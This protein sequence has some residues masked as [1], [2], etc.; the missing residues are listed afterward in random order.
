M[1]EIWKDIAGYEKMYQVSN[2]GRVRSLDRY[3][4][5]GY[6]YWLQRGKILKPCQQK[7]GYLNVDLSDGHSKSHK[8]RVHRLVAQ[9]FIPNPNNLPCVN[10]KDENPQNNKALN[11][12]WCDYR[13][14]NNY[15]N[16][17][18]KMSLTRQK[19][20]YKSIAIRNGR[21]ASKKVKQLD[22]NGKLLHI[23]PSQTEA[24]RKTGSKRNG[25]SDCCRG[26][27]KSHNGYLWEYA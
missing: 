24:A 10:H 12:E 23:Y 14:N 17:N 4:W 19:K 6:K 16:H 7:S 26:K 25:I 8:Y 13:Y 9:A 2:L 15:G 20:K 18:L 21:K 3:S 5:N 11:L 22:L 27:H 1:K